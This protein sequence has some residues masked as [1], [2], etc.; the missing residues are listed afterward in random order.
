[1][2]G[3]LQD[4][5]RPYLLL[6][7]RFF[8]VPKL[9]LVIHE[10]Q[11]DSAFRRRVIRY[12]RGVFINMR[13]KTDASYVTDV[14]ALLAYT[15]RLDTL[16]CRDLDLKTTT[17][18][19]VRAAALSVPGGSCLLQ[20]LDIQMQVGWAS[21]LRQLGQLTSLRELHILLEDDAEE[22]PLGDGLI[23]QVP[24]WSMP[25]LQLLSW[26]AD[27]PFD[28]DDPVRHAAWLDLLAR[29][30]F[31]AL[32]EVRFGL[33][34]IE[35]ESVEAARRFFLRHDAC[36]ERVALLATRHGIVDLV[37][38]VHVPQLVI[39]TTC[40][41]LADPAPCHNIVA[42]LQ[43][44]VAEIVFLAYP[45]NDDLAEFLDAI[46][47][48]HEHDG[49]LEG[50]LTVVVRYRP[51]AGRDQPDGERHWRANDEEGVRLDLAERAERWGKGFGVELRDELDLLWDGSA[52]TP[53]P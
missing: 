5:A 27:T 50:L 1:L 19:L 3:Q 7:L 41:D 48:A 43:P 17:F 44:E 26:Q 12:T 28:F 16:V 32:R 10:L 53:V 9:H 14:I 45:G 23:S 40:S 4:I 20:T 21:L 38:L 30:A 42:G 15:R 13:T 52:R 49:V 35:G 39:E 31:P 8:T 25:H 51:C 46:E 22:P 36:L 6:D 2:F 29:S 37:R 18:P 47:E 34:P 33:F 24:A 11:T